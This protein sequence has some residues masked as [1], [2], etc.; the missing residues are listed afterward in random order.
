VE[1]PRKQRNCCH[2]HHL[3]LPACRRYCQH[4]SECWQP[5]HKLCRLSFSQCCQLPCAGNLLRERQLIVGIG[6]DLR[7]RAQRHCKGE[8]AQLLG[9]A[10]P[11]QQNRKQRNPQHTEQVCRKVA[12]D[13]PQQ[14]PTLAAMRHRLC[15]T[16]YFCLCVHAHST[17][18]Q[19]SEHLAVNQG[20]VGSNPTRGASPQSIAA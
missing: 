15:R 8:D 19:R 17:V 9:T 14:A 5:Q 4:S 6:E 1:K 7:Q 20:V 18:A 11:P 13:C 3:R 10:E 16:P 12:P 2:E